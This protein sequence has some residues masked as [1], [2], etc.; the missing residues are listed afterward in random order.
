MT[1]EEKVKL[2]DHKKRVL[3]RWAIVIGILAMASFAA[4]GMTILD[5]VLKGTA[6]GGLEINW[7]KVDK[8]LGWLGAEIQD[9]TDTIREQFSLTSTDGVIISSVTPDSPAD[10]AGLQNGDVILAINETAVVNTLQIQQEIAGYAPGETVRLYVDKANGGRR[11]LYVEF[12]VDPSDVTPSQG[13]NIV[14]TADVPAAPVISSTSW[15]ISVSPLTGELREQFNIPDSVHGIV[16]VTVARNSAADSQGIEVGDVIVSVNKAPTPNLQ[17]FYQALQKNE[18]V[19]LDVYSSDSGKRLFAS[20]PDEG[21]FPP[22]VVLMSFV[23]ETPTKNRIAIASDR[24]TLDGTVY[25]R[26]ATSPHFIIYDMNKNEATAIA[27]PYAAQV[28]GMGIIVAQMVA[29]QNIDA[30]VVSGIGPQSFDVFYNAKVKVYGPVTG[31]VKTAIVNYQLGKLP[32]MS[33]ANLGGY[34]FSSVAT[35]PTGGSPWTED[36]DDEEEESG[37]KGLPPT[38]PPKGSAANTTLTAVGD[39]RANRTDM[40]ICP[41]CGAMV[42]HPASTSC[43]DMT[44]PICGSRL[45]NPTPGSDTRGGSALEAELPATDIALQVRPVTQVAGTAT[46][47]GGAPP[48]RITALQ[49][50]TSNLWALSGKPESIPPTQLTAGAGG[51]APTSGGGA[52]VTT[53]VCPLDGTTVT[54]P[55]G[56]PCAALQCPTCGGRMVSSASAAVGG[57]PAQATGGIQ[58]GG[59]PDDVPPIQQTFFLVAG[60]NGTVTLVPTSGKPE[61]IPPTGQ[62]VTPVAG[63]PVAGMS[64]AGMPVAG[65]PVAGMPVAGMQ[66]G[67]KPDDVPPIQQ[68]FFLV[69]GPNGTVT[70]VPTSSKPETIPP[71]GQAVTPVAGMPVAGMPV[72]GMPVAGMPVA[73]MQTG[74]K[75]DDVPPIQQTFF[76]VAG[77]NGTVTLVPTSSKPDTVPLLGQSTQGAAAQGKT[78]SVAGIPVAGMPVAGGPPADMGSS[79]GGAAVDGPA[80]GGGQAGSGAAQSGR[81]TLCICPMCKTTVTHPIGVPCAALNCPVCG[82]RLV[83]AEPGGTTG[84]A[85]MTTAAG[86]LTAQSTVVQVSTA[87]KKVVVP[88][89]GRSLKADVAP[90]LDDARYF[91][92][93]GLGK[94]E[95][96]RNP[97]YGTKGST[98]TQVAQFIVGEG[99]AAVICD[100]LSMTALKTLKDLKVKVYTGFG[101][102][103]QQALDIYATGNL[104]DASA[105]GVVDDEEEHGGGGPPASKSKARDKDKDGAELF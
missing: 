80:Q 24:D 56:V 70:L 13:A 54:H 64:V 82:S 51:Q 19:L 16:V 57:T 79:S 31:I 98:G 12:G 103:V 99:G 4:L 75:P 6:D 63:M 26:F 78:V 85:A 23:A 89:M 67:G 94:T 37:Y 65:M 3:R 41:N 46:T 87:S 105:T 32:E 84:G 50:T 42:T 90:L 104:K 40:C 14:R 35:L 86:V 5:R 93:V 81:S 96:V 77:P 10:D 20:L 92:M 55:V 60:P 49:Q 62:A 88:A 22:Q 74:G 58:T 11:A 28:R 45:M 83:N 38:I 36:S 29:R 1:H 59:K 43:S 73:G 69:A 44:C 48:S 47:P 102:T 15:G 27:N 72:A 71:T 17:S 101:G 100:N 76:L 66:T 2:L 7:P 21:S 53:C 68:T 97:Y 8:K 39:P 91:I 95:Y 25:A 34:G 30:V 33:E 18:A 52:Q 9:V 61:T